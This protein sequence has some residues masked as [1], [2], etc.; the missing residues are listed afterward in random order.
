MVDALLY[1]RLITDAA[2]TSLVADIN[3]V[4]PEADSGLPSLYY[5]LLGVEDQLSLSGPTGVK[6][7]NYAVDVVHID[8]TVID[9]ILT[10]VYDR[11]KTWAT[12]VVQGCFLDSQVTVQEDDGYHGQ[13]S[14]SLW[15]GD[16][17]AARTVTTPDEVSWTACDNTLTLGCDGLTLNGDPFTG[18]TGPAGPTGA[19]GGTG[20]TGP[21]GATGGTGPAGAAGGTGPTGATGP[22]GAP[23][24][25]ANPSGLIGMTAVNGS[26]TTYERSDATHAIDPAIVP[27]WTGLHTFNS[28]TPTGNDFSL[29]NNC[30]TFN[31][32]VGF[33]WGQ[34]GAEGGIKAESSM[35][36]IANGGITFN[37]SAMNFGV[38]FRSDNGFDILFT[39]L[40]GS[41][42]NVA[43]TGTTVPEVV[44]GAASQTANLT[45]W[46][47]SDGTV[48]ASID[49]AGYAI[50]SGIKTH[51]AGVGSTILDAGYSTIGVICTAGSSAAVALIA[52][53]VNSQS[54]N[55]QEWQN[56][57]GTA[58]ASIS[59]DGE[60]EET[61]AGKG[62][63][64]KSPDGT[65]YRITVA[66]GGTLTTTAI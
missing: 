56:F 4:H 24:T 6:K 25:P 61:T 13:Q 31:R 57:G 46:R 15:I 5:T 36:L 18:A 45:E 52:K 20:P 14:Y 53:G 64:L 59:K 41:M 10:A 47:K 66:N 51:A 28:P 58:L 38:T 29:I 17:S 54:A 3:P 50:V 32:K 63:I 2:I 37:P 22:A 19:A 21:P 11:L 60:L 43:N 9:T 34:G 62:I 8:P 27:T 35:Y 39:N 30:T 40:V 7:Y 33:F 55:L 16:D 65:R 26:A 49:N 48:L 44:K 42:I 1:D 12:P 23:Q